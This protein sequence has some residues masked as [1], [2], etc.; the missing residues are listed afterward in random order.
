MSNVKDCWVAADL[1]FRSDLISSGPKSPYFT[2]HPGLTTYL[3][4]QAGP[5]KVLTYYRTPTA[6]K[7]S[8]GRVWTNL[9]R[10]GMVVLWLVVVGLGFAFFLFPFHSSLRE[11]IKRNG[12][13]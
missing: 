4:I 11:S 8:G 10:K 1:L 13:Q 9:S 12:C 2:L 6:A 7:K 3:G 5:K